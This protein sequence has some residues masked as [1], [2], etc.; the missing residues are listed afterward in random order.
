[1]VC[2]A[3]GARVR[4]SRVL[5][6][7]DRTERGLGKPVRELVCRVALGGTQMRRARWSQSREPWLRASSAIC[8]AEAVCRL[9]REVSIHGWRFCWPWS[10]YSRAWRRH[11]SLSASRA[12]RASRVCPVSYSATASWIIA[13]TAAGSGWTWSLVTVSLGTAVTYCL[14]RCG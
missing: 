5:G 2:N 9:A 14:V 13:A 6:C 8:L 7:H 4:C 3:C 1:A 10:W 12:Q 11:S